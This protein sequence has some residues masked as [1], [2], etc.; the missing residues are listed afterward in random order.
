[1][2]VAG[3]LV[4]HQRPDRS[5]TTAGRAWPVCAR[6]SGIYLAAA[7]TC[8][9]ALVLPAR[10]R[11]RPDA[12][13]LRAWFGVALAPVALTWVLERAGVLALSN[14]TRAVSGAALGTLVALALVSLLPRPR[15]RPR[16]LR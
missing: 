15:V 12:A 16:D 10:W 6:C 1:V 3:A 5:F 13:T 14:G 4:C 8:L 9:A 11:S 7:A 2:Y